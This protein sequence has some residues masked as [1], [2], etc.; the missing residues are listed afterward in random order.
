MMHKAPV[1]DEMEGRV[2]NPAGGNAWTPD[3]KIIG[4]CSSFLNVKVALNLRIVE[5]EHELQP[6]CR[7]C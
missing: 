4:R 7:L 1:P 2:K 5:H 6:V 3:I